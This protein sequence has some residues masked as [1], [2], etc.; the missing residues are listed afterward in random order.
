MQAPMDAQYRPEI[1]EPEAQQHWEEKQIFKASE[2]TSKPKY[3]CLSMFPYP[4]GKLHMGHV[5]NYTI[6][7]VLSRYHRMKGYNVLQPMGWDAFGLPAENAALANNVA[8]AGWTYA[9]IEYMKKQLKS[10]GLAIDWNR[11]LA[12]CKPDYYRWEQWL[13]T[14]L[15]E[16]GVIYKK[17]ASVNWDPVDHT[18][19]ANEQ[20]ID[21]R[22]WRSG[23]LVEKRDIPMYFFRITDYAEELLSELDNL[24][25]WPERV[26]TMQRNWIGKS[27]G[28]EIHFPL[29]ARHQDGQD[30]LKVF[31]T[32]ADT[33]FGVTYVAVAAEH[34]LA[35]KAAQGNPELAAFIAECKQGSVA[36][37]DMATMEKKGMPTGLVVYHPFTNEP[38]P[39]WVANYVLMGYGEG[40]VMAVPAHDERDF[41]FAKKYGLAI[42][43]VIKPGADENADGHASE[44]TLPLAEAY[45]EHGILFDSGD[46]SGRISQDAIEKMA[47]VL[48]NLKLGDRRTTWRLR[49][50][51]I[52]RQRYWGCPIPIIHCPT[53]GDVPVPADQLPV[54]LPENV[55]IDV[56]SPLKKMPEWSNCTCPKCGGPAERETD[57][58][59]TFVESSWYYARYACPD[60]ET[61]MLDGRAN[62]WLPVDQYIGGIEHAILHLL[63]ARFFHKL[64]RDEG[65]VNSSEPFANLLTQGMVVAETYYRDLADGKKQWI[66]PAEVEVERDAKG[67]IVAARLIADGQ[68]VVIGGIEKMS[69]SKNNG[70][71]PQ[72]LID[73]YGADT[74]RLFMMFAAPPEQSLEWSDAG[75]EGAHRFLKRLWKMVYEHVEAGIVPAFAGGELPEALQTLRRQLHQTI[76]KV[77][78][79]IERRK[80][81]NTAIAANMELMNALS[82]VGGEIEAGDPLTR[83]VKQ[84][85]LEAIVLMLA[86]IVPHIC[87]ILIKA[88]KPGACLVGSP[89][90]QADAAA[91]VLDE[92]ELMLQVN[93]KLRGKIKVAAEA[94]REAIEQAALASTE[95]TRHLDGRPAKKVV[96]VPGRLVNVVG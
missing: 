45:T 57:T 91:M 81:F 13:F 7:D 27:F 71:D 75:V 53:C 28:V 56:G 93:G 79:D 68:P 44:L 63:Y 12:T 61:A 21:G 39:V 1:I 60:L 49:D 62:H 43:P 14:R 59:D 82:K 70:V 69:K 77:T 58:M 50:W 89:W 42:K 26:K 47:L 90:P 8:P 73:Q 54:V 11:E 10:L 4:S 66:N 25:G 33:L 48:K 96:V 38:L 95:V 37:A 83:A 51:G 88:L 15:F 24:P 29:D 6:G 64:M 3:Y 40:A 85:A 2:D 34:P 32:R 30:V 5:R 55:T 35:Q 65:L 22:G 23:A 80:Q 19:L 16:K 86:P 17:M 92:I 9:N 20:V 94:S 72:A 76:T 84:E 78:D 74:A 52:S 41:A 31:T 18:V 46:F 87:R 36:E 67:H